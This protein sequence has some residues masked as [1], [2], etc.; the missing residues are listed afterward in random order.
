MWKSDGRNQSWHADKGYFEQLIIVLANVIECRIRFTE[1]VIRWVGKAIKLNVSA[2][3][4]MD[5]R[6]WVDRASI[7]LKAHT[8]KTQCS[9]SEHICERLNVTLLERVR[10]F[11]FGL[12]VGFKNFEH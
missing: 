8:V 3:Y 9:Q 7:T 6:S 4:F 5:K 2:S 10:A 11:R 1:T 12:N